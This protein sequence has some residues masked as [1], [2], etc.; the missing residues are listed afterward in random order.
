M[1]KLL[2]I[3]LLSI[4]MVG[5]AQKKEDKREQLSAEER[6]AKM[7]TKMQKSLNLTDAQTKEVEAIFL[8]RVEKNAELREK[9]KNEKEERKKIAEDLKAENKATNEELKKVLT[10]EQLAVFEKNQKERK[11]KMRNKKEERKEAKKAEKV[12]S[13]E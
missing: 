5:I 12:H 9:I 13:E 1:K 11:E 7:T 2:V 8:K 3:A 4:G 6:V 10:K